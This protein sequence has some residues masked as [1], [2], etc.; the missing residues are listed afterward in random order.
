M[1]LSRRR[2]T[3][4]ASNTTATSLLWAARGEDGRRDNGSQGIKVEDA[5]VNEFKS[6]TKCVRV[7]RDGAGDQHPSLPV[8]A[9]KAWLGLG[10]YGVVGKE[11]KGMVV[12]NSIPERAWVSAVE[13]YLL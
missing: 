2:S 10:K 6:M 12:N 4:P 11:L 7:L 3:P 13:A 8:M 1:K 5:A 9:M